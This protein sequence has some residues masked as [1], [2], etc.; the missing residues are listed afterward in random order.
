MFWATPLLKIIYKLITKITTL[1]KSKINAIGLPILALCWVGFFWGTTWLA[2]KE[3]VKQMPGLQLAAIRQLIAGSLYLC[4][5]LLKR[6]PWP[7][8]KQWKTIFI[9]SLLNFAL[10]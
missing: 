9:L 10:S 6:T 8:G 3:G 4:F 7:K 5:F 2:S 1:F